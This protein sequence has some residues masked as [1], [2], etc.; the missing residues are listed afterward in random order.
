MAFAGLKKDKDRDN[1][2]TWL[3]ENVRLPV[4][5]FASLANDRDSAKLS[6]DPPP[7]ARPTT[8]YYTRSCMVVVIPGYF[9]GQ[10]DT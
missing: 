9:I 10:Y 2:I 7:V 5:P 1:L 8:H 3:K 4:F 6:L